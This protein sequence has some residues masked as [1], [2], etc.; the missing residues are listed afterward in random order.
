MQLPADAAGAE[1][2]S[3]QGKRICT[4][5][6]GNNANTSSLPL[7]SGCQKA[8]TKLNI[9]KTSVIFFSDDRHLCEIV[10]ACLFSFLFITYAVKRYFPASSKKKQYLLFFR[11]I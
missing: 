8:S 3:V 1:L 9:F 5:R 10:N 2:Y 6:R 4:I 11:Y 7:P